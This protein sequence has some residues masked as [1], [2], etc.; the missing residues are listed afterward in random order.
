MEKAAGWMK[1]IS[2]EDTANFGSLDTYACLLYK[3]EKLNGGDTS[4][5]IKLEENVLE[6]ATKRKIMKYIALFSSTLEEMKQGGPIWQ[7][8]ARLD[9]EQGH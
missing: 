3:A 9:D 1:A 8:K 4:D 6:E 7:N 5:A 2:H